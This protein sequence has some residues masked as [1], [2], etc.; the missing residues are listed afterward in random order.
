[1]GVKE[2]ASSYQELEELVREEMRKIYTEATIDHAMNPR[3]MGG[4]ENADGFGKVTGPCGDTM[5]IWL[6]IKNNTVVEAT[7]LTDGCGTSIA[8]GSMVTELAKGKSISEA[9]K[10]THQDVLDAFG[11]LPEESIHCAFLAAN[12]LREAIKDYFTFKN[13]PWRRAYRQH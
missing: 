8:A 13:E 10:I 6:K 5:E 11:G 2:M 7:F 1:M 3:N 9:L 4:M 12:T